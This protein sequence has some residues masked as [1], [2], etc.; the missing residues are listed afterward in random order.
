MTDTATAAILSDR[1]YET[2]TKGSS[3]GP[4]SRYEVKA[5]SDTSGRCQAS[6]HVEILN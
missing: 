3:F 5:T 1:I 6:C 2:L 4:S